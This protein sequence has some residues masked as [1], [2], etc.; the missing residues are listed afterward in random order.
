MLT[1]QDNKEQMVVIIVSAFVNL[2]FKGNVKFGGD[3]ITTL[4][5]VNSQEYIECFASCC[6]PA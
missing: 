5:V 4:A 6:S 1:S 2:K 3:T